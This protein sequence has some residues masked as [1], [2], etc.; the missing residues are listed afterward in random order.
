MHPHVDAMTESRVAEK[1]QKLVYARYQRLVSYPAQALT[2]KATV[3]FACTRVSSTN[4]NTHTN[5]H[6]HTH[7]F[8]TDRGHCHHDN[9][10]LPPALC[11]TPRRRT[12]LRSHLV[13]LPPLAATRWLHGWLCPSV[14]PAEHERGGGPEGGRGDI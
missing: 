7:G 2:W 4:A 5:T 13:L 12:L 10:R 1:V 11:G 9:N 6:T 8:V 14:R 3:Y